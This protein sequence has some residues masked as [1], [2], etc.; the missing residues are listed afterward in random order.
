MAF[1][2]VRKS[3]APEIVVEQI[4]KKLQSGEITTGA[5]LP[6]QRELALS[7]GVGRSSMREA[8]NALAVMGYLDVQQGRGTFIAQELPGTSP[9]ISKL[10]AALKAGSL[11]DVIELRETLE[12]KAAELAAERAESLHLRRLKQALRDME[13]SRENYRRFL[14]ADVEFHTTLAEAT[15]NQIFSEILRFLLEKVVGHHETFKTTLISLEY[16]SRSIHTLKQVLAC[17]KREDG[18]GAAEWMRE[19]LNAIRRELKDIL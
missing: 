11:L 15:T 7:F 8:L 10:Q 14:Q 9:S 18:R 4:L 19:H 12:C 1:E 16:R 13:D 5:R 6:S 2:A 3:T 17:V